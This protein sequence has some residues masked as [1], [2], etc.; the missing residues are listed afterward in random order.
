MKRR[1]STR[2][3]KNPSALVGT[4]IILIFLLTA[5]I[6]PA[7]RSDDPY[8]LNLSQKLKAPG[9]NGH[10]LGTDNFGRDL[11]TRIIY[12]SRI[13]LKVCL[14][15]VLGGGTIGVII[16][17]ISGYIGGHADTILMRV[18]E[19]FMAVPAFILAMVVVVTLGPGL[20]SAMTA[21]IVV[22]WPAYA[23][24]TRGQMLAAKEKEYVE[25][26]RA[27]G[28]SHIR[29]VF[30]HILPN[31]FPPILIQATM[32]FGYAILSAAGLSFLGLGAQRPMPEWGLM[33]SL[34][35]TYLES[36]WW[37]PTFPG[38]TIALLV[39]AFNLAGDA[40]RDI[41]DPKQI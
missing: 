38:L 16:G 8:K 17:A 28:A 41:F 9:E 14:M 15:I 2:F 37:Y 5:L 32:D 21:M 30:L 39:F 13:S 24:I 3:L 4:G 11:L 33:V 34:G 36:A 7:L 22:W 35:S 1:F 29:I 25:A 6:G 12:G 31:I 19:I 20:Y 23:R 18:T 26:A 10:I 27:L 40:L